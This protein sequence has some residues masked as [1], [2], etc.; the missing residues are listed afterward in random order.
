MDSIKKY[1]FTRWVLI[2]TAKIILINLKIE[3]VVKW[4]K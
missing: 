4:A 2:G 1:I 3:M